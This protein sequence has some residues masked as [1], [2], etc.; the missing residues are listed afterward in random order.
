MRVAHA[1][2]REGENPVKPED[3]LPISDTQDLVFGVAPRPVTCGRDVEIGKGQ[4]LPEINFTLPQMSIDEGTWGE[5]KRQYSEIIQEVCQRAVDLHV[6]AL[7]VEFELL[8]PMTLTPEW[9]GQITEVLSTALDR[10]HRDYGLSSALR[11]TP[12]DVRANEH[13]PRMRSGTF[14]EKTIRSFELCAASGAD[15]LSIESTGGKEIHDDAIM[16]GNLAGIVF[17]LGVL[18]VR[19]VNFLWERVVKIAEGANVV[20]AGDTACAFANTAMILAE[21]RHIPKVLAAVVRVASVARSLQAY[22]QGARGPSKDCAYEGPYIKVLTGTPISMEGKSS[23]CAHLSSVGNV[24]SACCD[25]WSNESVQNVR[26]LSAHAPVVSMEELIYDCRL[27]NAALREGK[28]SARMLQ[29]W[30]VESDVR[31]DPQAYV[32]KPDLVVDISRS[33]AQCVTPLEMTLC[34]VDQ[35]LTRLR[36]ATENK[37]LTMSEAELRWLDLLS[38]QLEGIPIDEETLWSLMKSSPYSKKMIPEE[39]L[40]N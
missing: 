18:A 25:L 28:S 30:L 9:G 10:F 39:Y 35:T 4:V 20:P 19:D 24:A 6:P 27:M 31:L 3:W 13:P 5:V 26:L 34:A 11:V 37:E 32:L 15:L 22:V 16:A 12:V 7:V 1:N 36:K 23:A 8:P 21:K 2:Q 17:S 29:K 14:L 33:L 38:G 40:L